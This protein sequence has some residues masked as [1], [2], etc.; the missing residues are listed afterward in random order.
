MLFIY[1]Q[2]TVYINRQLYVVAVVKVPHMFFCLLY[3]PNSP[4]IH[5][6]PCKGEFFFNLFIKTIL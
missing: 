2:F 5:Y 3:H 1:K 6:L 4:S